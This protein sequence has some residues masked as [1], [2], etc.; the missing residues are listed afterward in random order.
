MLE[1]SHDPA[2]NPASTVWLCCFGSPALLSRPVDGAET[3][4][5]PAGKPLLVLAILA[6][7]F[8][9]KVSRDELAV[10]GWGHHDE[11]HAK[12]SLRQALHRLRRTLGGE[13]IAADDHSARLATAIPSDWAALSAAV[14]AG[15]DLA[16]LHGLH[17]DFLDGIEYGD[18]EEPNEWINAERMRWTLLLRAAALREGRRALAHGETETAIGLA[19]RTLTI[20]DERLAGWELYLDA[21][22]ATESPSRLEGGLARLEAA[23][24]HGHLAVADPAI[25]KRLILRHR[26]ALDGLR[27]ERDGEAAPTIV[28]VLPFTGRAALLDHLLTLLTQQTDGQQRPLAM[29]AGPGFGKSRMLLELRSRLMARTVTVARVEAIATETSSPWALLNRVVERVATLP[30][31]V[32]V[33][34]R[35]AAHLVALNPQLRARF[36]G[37]TANAIASLPTEDELIAALAEL[38]G[39]VG[40]TR[41]LV[42][43]IDDLH[44]GDERSVAVIHGALLHPDSGKVRCL[45]TTRDDAPKQF[46]DCHTLHLPSLTVESLESLIATSLPAIDAAQRAAAANAMLLVTGGVP[47]YVARAVQRLAALDPPVP[48][49]ADDL[50]SRMLAA[51]PS[52]ELYRDPALP[53]AG[54]GRHVLEYL[55]LVNEPVQMEE[56]LA[57]LGERERGSL[58]ETLAT[59]QR[60][61]SIAIGESG[62][63]LSHDLVL[64]QVVEGLPDGRRRV[65]DLQ[66]AQWLVTHGT[67]LHEL[68]SA[69]RIYLTYGAKIQV[70]SAVRTWCRRW[71]GGARGSALAD[72][73][74]PPQQS[75][76]L[77]WQVAAAATPAVLWRLSLTTVFLAMAAWVGLNW[78]QSPTALRAENTPRVQPTEPGLT[79]VRNMEPPLFTVRDR[80]GRISTRLDGESLRV[81][82]TSAS[83]DSVHL[84]PLPVVRNGRMS[85][86]SLA[87]FTH[88]MDSLQLT[89]QVG[90]LPAHALTVF[91]GYSDQS[92]AIAGGLINGRVI[93]SVRP[94][95][96]VNPGDSLTGSVI[97]VYTTPA[98]AALWIM[99]QSST[100]A[101]LATDTATVMTMHTG[102]VRAIGEVR[103]ARR[104]PLTPGRYWMVWTF[105]AEPGAA[106][107]LSLTNWKCGTPHWNDQDNLLQVPDSVLEHAWGSGVITARREICDDPKH[108][109]WQPM[110]YPTATLRVTVRAVNQ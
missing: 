21:L 108:I 17:G 92:L 69:V 53:A 106:W 40:E 32:G 42:L 3:V 95:V 55:A 36:P 71:P 54:V 56:L 73:L 46:R 16:V 87:V 101:T 19:E 70:Y 51:I 63:Q 109:V 7:R 110:H 88:A 82:G 43:L 26:H 14:S 58:D 28:G 72:L 102:A 4:L 90:N 85:A 13:A 65:L 20:R 50:G 41:P 52:L 91:R 25:W 39:A 61:G 93:D 38:L 84:H 10:L 37:V 94:E 18:G 45:A 96:T 89:F 80:L 104:A 12:G 34:P 97:F 31:A 9:A 79:I 78:F 5:L 100:M 35:A 22:Q 103:I 59:L 62:V 6:T 44:W 48:D 86:D 57:V 29:I 74:L 23:G 105:A 1:P 66:R 27:L 8:P 30:G 49:Q 75:R 83:V 60:Q 68:Q 98:Q 15:D 2:V 81:V 77:R 47:H 11:L 24:R 99:A 64:Q 76:L 67:G 107:I 33:D